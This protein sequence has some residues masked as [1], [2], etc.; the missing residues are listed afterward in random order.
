MRRTDVE[1]YHCGTIVLRFGRDMCGG[2][3]RKEGAASCA[4]GFKGRSF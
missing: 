4:A 3:I 2:R 1:K